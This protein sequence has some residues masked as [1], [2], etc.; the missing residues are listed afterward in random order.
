MSENNINKAAAFLAIR[1]GYWV[2]RCHDSR[3]AQQKTTA[4]LIDDF[5]LELFGRF[6][7]DE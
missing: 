1:L 3:S 2:E 6:N 4:E 7:P 5:A